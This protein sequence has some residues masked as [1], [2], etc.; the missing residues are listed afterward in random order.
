MKTSKNKTLISSCIVLVM[1]WLTIVSCE[2]QTA[3]VNP[4][5]I[6]EA[7]IGEANFNPQPEPPP[8][9]FEFEIVGDPSD[10]WTGNFPDFRE[11]RIEVETLSSMMRGKTIHVVQSWVLVPP[12]PIFPPEPIVPPDPIVPPEPVQISLMGIINLANGKVVLNGMS[13]ELGVNVHVRGQAMTLGSGDISIGGE[14]MFNPQPEPPPG[15]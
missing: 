9:V 1:A 13:D 2:S 14:V 11:G 5:D 6:R 3:V 10:D 15:R 8:K 4:L 12:E 7:Q